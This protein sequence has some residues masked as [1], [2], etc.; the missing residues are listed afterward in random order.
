[1]TAFLCTLQERVAHT[2][3]A[4]E[5]LPLKGELQTEPILKVEPVK[6]AHSGCF[7]IH[8]IFCCYFFSHEVLVKI[9]KTLTL[10]DSFEDLATTTKWY[11]SNSIRASTNSSDASLKRTTKKEREDGGQG[12]VRSM[13]VERDDI[14]GCVGSKHYVSGGF[15]PLP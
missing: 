12:R 10:H 6:C 1:M 7:Q 9:C 15:T 5:G 11:S 14:V 13:Y 3:R 4:W 2:E 8:N